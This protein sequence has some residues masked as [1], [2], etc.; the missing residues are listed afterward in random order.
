MAAFFGNF[1]LQL[2][3][4]EI[5]VLDLTCN[6][7]GVRISRPSRQIDFNESRGKSKKHYYYICSIYT[8]FASSPIKLPEHKK[9]SRS[10]DMES[11]K[12]YTLS[13]TG[14]CLLKPQ[15]HCCC[16]GRMGGLG[17]VVVW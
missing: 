7:L 12:D 13:V 14:N 4:P 2:H 10:E 6:R 3:P 8:E 1:V 9:T 5:V 11:E 16:S 15:C 17:A